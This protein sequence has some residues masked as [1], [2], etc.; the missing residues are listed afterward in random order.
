MITDDMPV[1][2]IRTRDQ[3]GTFLVAVLRHGVSGAVGAGFAGKRELVFGRVGRRDF[4]R[5]WIDGGNCGWSE[6]G[7]CRMEEP[8]LRRELG[9]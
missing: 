6:G 8:M 9:E 7:S 2:T 5:R 1:L 3:H 4:S